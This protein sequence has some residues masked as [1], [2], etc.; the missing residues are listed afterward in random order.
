MIDVHL[1]LPPNVVEGLLNRFHIY[2]RDGYQGYFGA[3]IFS[4]IM[5]LVATLLDNDYRVDV[6][7]GVTYKIMARKVEV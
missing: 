6:T 3:L 5:S 2:H 4:E 1:L 7:P